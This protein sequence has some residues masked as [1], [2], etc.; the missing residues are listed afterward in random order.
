MTDNPADTPAYDRV[1]IISARTPAISGF[2]LHFLFTLRQISDILRKVTVYPVPFSPGHIKGVAVWREK[3]LPVLSLEAILGL[4][5][6]PLQGKDR[7]IVIKGG[8]GKWGIFK[9]GS[10][11]RIMPL[12]S[13]CVPANNIPR[14]HQSIMAKAIYEW[15]EGLLV[16]V[17]IEKILEGVTPLFSSADHPAQEFVI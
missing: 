11:I 1:L 7:F 16:I 8:N 4:K 6:V 12:P 10:E 9:A 2:T 17:D 13:P 14:L 5:E 3:V 15:P